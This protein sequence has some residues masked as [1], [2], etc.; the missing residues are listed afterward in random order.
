MVDDRVLVIVYGLIG[1]LFE[2]LD[3]L[4]GM[5]GISDG[6]VLDES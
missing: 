2:M 3:Y 5:E 4:M 6:Y 1:G